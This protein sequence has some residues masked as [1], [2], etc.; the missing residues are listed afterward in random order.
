MSNNVVYLHGKPREIALTT[1]VGFSEHRLC[2]QLLS[3]NKLTS[4]RFVL[5]AATANTPRHKS[6]LRSL[7]DSKSEVILDTNCAE[8]SVS[9]RFSGAA[10]SAPWAVDGRPLDAEDFVAGTNR[11]VIEPIARFAVSSDVTAILSPAHFL[12][13]RNLDW[14][15]IDL[16]SCAAL[17]KSLDSLG[18]AHIPIDY[19]IIATYAQL[20]DPTF[21]KAMIDGIRNSPIDRVWLRISGFGADATGVGISRLVEAIRDFHSLGVPII[22][23]HVG[24]IASL[25]LP[26]LGAVSG[27]ATGIEGKQRFNAGDWLKPAG[28]GGGGG[29]KRIFISGLDR[30][31]LIEEMRQFFDETRTARQLFGCSDP[32]CCGDIDKM[33]RNPA[34]HLAVQTSKAVSELSD[35]P[36]TLRSKHF[37]DRYLSESAKDA[38]RA[39][40]IKNMTAELRKKIEASAKKLELTKEALSGLHER[41]GNW[42]FPPEARF[43][44]G[45]RQTELNFQEKSS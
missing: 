18:G 39:T 29:S 34:A 21:R 28:T 5:E 40:G 31:F 9:G 41:E 1:R 26:A 44:I 7:K 8:L 12:G 19:P 23:D 24:G 10:R 25:A 6:L 38:R 27:F 14:L 37:L 22:A 4:R 45:S 30:S 20:R 43:R 2:E 32:A 36:E 16:E 3:A 35:A 15:S 33:L 17:R 11:S 42:E 13:D